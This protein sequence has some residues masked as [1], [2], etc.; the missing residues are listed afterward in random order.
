MTDCFRGMVDRRKLLSLISRGVYCYRFSN[1]DLKYFLTIFDMIN[2]I[3][4]C[5]K[6][7]SFYVPFTGRRTQTLSSKCKADQTDFTNW[8]S[9][10]TSSLVEEEISPNPEVL[11]VASFTSMEKLKRK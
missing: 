6:L 9:F 7:C 11:S 10:L 5:G 2:S 4:N 1:A 3:A 8:I